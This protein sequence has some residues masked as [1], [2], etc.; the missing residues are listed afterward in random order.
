MAL[1]A[2][3]NSFSSQQLL[4]FVG[5]AQKQGKLT[6]A[7][8]ADLKAS[9]PTVS[10]EQ[11]R[12]SCKD[13]P[14]LEV[15]V[16][17]FLNTQDKLG[18][19][20][21]STQRSEFV[22][23]VDF[24]AGKTPQPEKQAK[25]Q[26]ETAL[27]AIDDRSQRVSAEIDRLKGRLGAQ[28]SPSQTAAIKSQIA[29][30]SEELAGLRQKRKD[31]V[32]NAS[33]DLLAGLQAP[34][35]E[36][37]T[38]NGKS[39]LDVVLRN[40]AAVDQELN[41]ALRMK[42]GAAQ[43]EE[44]TGL[45]LKSGQSF[46]YANLITAQAPELHKLLHVLNEFRNGHLTAPSEQDQKVLKDF[47]L[48]I[49][50]KQLVNLMTM[51]ALR[52]ESLNKMIE[53]A[54]SLERVQKPGGDATPE[55]KAVARLRHN[56][57]LAFRSS[58]E[59]S[60]ARSGLDVRV[61]EL[62]DANVNLETQTRK[63]TES[64]A[65]LSSETQVLDA[66]TEQLQ[67]AN[68]A[69]TYLTEEFVPIAPEDPNAPPVSRRPVNPD[70]AIVTPGTD[71]QTASSAG[72]AAVADGASEPQAGAGPDGKAERPRR[73]H[74]PAHLALT[75]AGLA[76]Y[77]MQIQANRWG[78]LSFTINGQAV[79]PRSFMLAARARVLEE[80]AGVE[81]SR[82]RVV[83]LQGTVR[84]DQEAVSVA[85]EEVTRA[86]TN[87]D[88]AFERNERAIADA[89]S[90][91]PGLE[92]ALADPN[93]PPFMRDLARGVSADFGKQ[94][95]RAEAEM[96][97]LRALRAELHALSAKN[98]AAAQ[99]AQTSAHLALSNADRAVAKADKTISQLSNW[100]SMSLADFIDA[101]KNMPK[102]RI[103]PQLLKEALGQV[104]EQIHSIQIRL[105]QNAGNGPKLQALSDDLQK[106]LKSVH[107]L[108]QT[109]NQSES[110]SQQIQSQL[111]TA[112]MQ[113]L[114]ENCSYHL[115]KLQ[116]LQNHGHEQIAAQLAESTKAL[117][118]SLF[119]AQSALAE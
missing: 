84:R 66:K 83:E 101:L 105:E 64:T 94:I 24:T 65:R 57:A 75:N 98:Q 48:Q 117:R 30:F 95:A 106:L 58:Q 92:E 97:E 45:G 21:A 18:M 61:R 23:S 20:G 15:V 19:S 73:P 96:P 114:Q 1:S 31:I 86:E 93:L 13:H 56:M 59:L 29:S 71:G 119:V 107:S 85:R 77:G 80:K 72:P 36:N 87:F 104:H 37:Q 60:A 9:G 100:L 8:A 7:E 108:F 67:T 41:S 46:I 91:Q 39:D 3:G 33:D 74:N 113:R 116:A 111:T 28:H 50:G 43:T 4:D 47:G 81:A 14:Q 49:K 44:V 82:A 79:D 5:Q 34:G 51:E 54:V 12:E 55:G 88:Q 53:T 32:R 70:A 6:Q 62:R 22:K 42:E 89:K 69:F 103:G 17:A 63:L 38:H 76:R 99:A 16:Q 90:R 118:G 2:A 78:V 68:T 115:N 35:A 102:L 109:L 40:T 25:S 52:P 112:N 27:A 11:L 110:E 26:T 10:L